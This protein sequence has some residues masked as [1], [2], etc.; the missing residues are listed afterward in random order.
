MRENTIKVMSRQ[1]QTHGK[2]HLMPGVMDNANHPRIFSMVSATQQIHST[3]GNAPHQ[4]LLHT[5]PTLHT[6]K[7]PPTHHTHADEPG[8]T[9]QHSTRRPAPHREH[10]N[11][12]HDDAEEDE[13]NKD[14]GDTEQLRKKRQMMTQ[15]NARRHRAVPG[16]GG[17]TI[18]RPVPLPST[19][20]VISGVCPHGAQCPGAP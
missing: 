15:G 19:S 13:T 10:Q 16:S 18:R 20:L 12:T 2:S 6:R 5:A 11:T 3:H 1:K 4:Q 14:D 9:V 17:P 8:H 7:K